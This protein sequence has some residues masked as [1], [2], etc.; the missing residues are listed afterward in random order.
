MW[1]EIGGKKWEPK[2][3]WRKN[4]TINN[5][6]SREYNNTAENYGNSSIRPQSIYLS[7]VRTATA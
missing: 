6:G 7:R 4:K 2:E 3:G 1:D 5:E